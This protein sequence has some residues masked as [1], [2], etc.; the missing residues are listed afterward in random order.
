M[1]KLLFRTLLWSTLAALTLELCARLDDYFTQGAPLLANY[2][3]N[4]LNAFDKI[5]NRGR[6]FAHYL[7]WQLNSL[8]FRNPELHPHLPRLMCVGSS[9]TFGQSETP[10]MEWPRQLERLLNE[11]RPGKLQIVNTGFAGETFPTSVLRLPERLAT[12]RPTAVLFYPSV[13]H[14]L[15]IPFIPSYQGPPPPAPTRPRMLARIETVVKQSAPVWLMTWL[16]LRQIEKDAPA[17]GPLID[18]IPQ[19]LIDRFEKDLRQAVHLTRA[20]GAAPILITHANRFGRSVIPEERFMLI[21]WRKFYP[22]LREDGFLR[23]ENTMNAVTRRVAHDE[24]VL[25]IDP[26]P[27]MPPGPRYFSDFVHFTNQGATLFSRFLA[28]SLAYCS[29]VGPS[30]CPLQPR[31]TIL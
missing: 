26:A 13:A 14:Y 19:P 31:G 25:L 6:P 17:Y 30:P 11:N 2:D 8:G 3:N 16:R 22:N 18:N 20:A 4:V 5:G 27:D 10:G 24:N 12:V 1:A 21:A 15:S 7:K 9:E 28:R 29:F 23:M